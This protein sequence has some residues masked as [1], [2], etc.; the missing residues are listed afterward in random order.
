VDDK[1]DVRARAIA[2]LQLAV[3]SGSEGEVA[4]AVRTAFVAGV[5]HYEIAE[6]SGLG[7]SGVLGILGMT[8]AP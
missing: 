1:G 8:Q 3:H 6:L 4:A 5:E 7:E 2:D